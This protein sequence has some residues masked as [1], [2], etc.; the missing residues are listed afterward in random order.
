MACHHGTWA[1]E[2]WPFVEEGTLANQWD[3]INSFH[4]QSPA[5]QEAIVT[6][7]FCPS[8]RSPQLSVA[9]EDARPY[10]SDSTK[11]ALADY[12]ACIGDGAIGPK[13][14]W[15]QDGA[16]GVFVTN[17]STYLG[18]PAATDPDLKFRGQPFYVSIK[19]VTDG[20]SKTFLVG[21]K[22]APSYGYGYYQLPS[23]ELVYD[24]SIYNADEPRVVGR[25][26]GSG[27]GLARH[28]DEQ[29]N[30]NFGG[31]HTGVCQFVF[32]DGS[33][34]AIAVEID[35][36]ILGYLAHRKDGKTISDQDY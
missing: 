14:D 13:A 18:C 27:Y 3:K 4:F 32:A 8:R 36:V 24:T 11:G 31:P 21:E 5:S 35:E 23:S 33:A 19:G 15:F 2:L 34:R 29:V 25:F 12:A 28:P 22:Q 17:S 26:A 7:Y 9:G 30:I 1:T 6:I 20:T 10:Q 16:N